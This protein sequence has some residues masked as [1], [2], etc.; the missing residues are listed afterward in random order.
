MATDDIT[1]RLQALEE[2]LARLERT[3]LGPELR[4]RAS[5]AGAPHPAAPAR[6]TA[7]VVRPP[8]ATAA[9]AAPR[10]DEDAQ[11]ATITTLLGWS[12]AA[13]LVL[14][15]AYLIRLA[16]DAGWLTPAVQVGGAAAFGVALIVAGFTLSR[17]AR[18][19]ASLLPAAGIAVLFLSVYGAHLLYHLVGAG[20][21]GS[22]VMVVCAASIGL[23]FAFDSDLYALFAVAGSYSAPFLRAAAVLLAIWRC[24]SAPGA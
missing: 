23:C 14:A 4:P 9:R 7:P 12:G 10:A 8:A 11:T 22:A 17:A 1:L 24:T 13:A 5:P 16:I 3:V 18:D 19:Y 6:V 15:A 21:A 20:E 2:R